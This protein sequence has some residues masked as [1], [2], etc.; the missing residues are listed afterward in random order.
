M[1][2]L[3]SVDRKLL[4]CELAC[5][6]AAVACCILLMLRRGAHNDD[7]YHLPMLIAVAAT[8][9]LRLHQQHEKNE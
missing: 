6:L 7:A 1:T 9:Y 2:A 3:N 8:V 5:L 4:L